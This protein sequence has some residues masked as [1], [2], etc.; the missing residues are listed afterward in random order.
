MRWLM[1][2]DLSAEE[3]LHFSTADSTLSLKGELINDSKTNYTQRIKIGDQHYYVKRYLIP[4]KH[5]RKFFGSSRVGREWRNLN[6]FRNNGIPTPR[7]IAMGEG[8]RWSSQYWG[9]IVTV[10]AP[11]T[12][13]LRKIYQNQPELLKNRKWL[14]KAIVKLASA[15]AEMHKKRFLHNDLQWRNVLISY[16]NEPEVYLIDCPAG[17]SIYLWGNRR[18]VVRDLAFLDKMAKAALSRTDRL[19]F[20]MLYKNV[21]RL[22]ESEKQEIRRIL[23]FLLNKKGNRSAQI[24]CS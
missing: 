18:G 1:A 16:P 21:N 19:R 15:I 13:D 6:W 14:R 23:N 7:V 10:E 2:S 20:Y 8:G 24:E 5:L 12:I 11:Q 4:G 22:R 17:R 3:Q 9:V